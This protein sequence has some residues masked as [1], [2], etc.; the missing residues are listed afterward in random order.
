[1]KHCQHI[2]RLLATMLAVA[3][4]VFVAQ[5]EARAQADTSDTSINTEMPLTKDKL[6][7]IEDNLVKNLESQSIGMVIGG[8]QVV[9]E[10]KAKAPEHG[11]SKVIIPLMRILKDKTADRGARMMAALALFDVNSDRGNFAIQREAELSDD[12]L[13]KIVCMNLSKARKEKGAK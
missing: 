11:F 3:A 12:D 4:L 1:M 8:A 10:L 7:R 6:N 2:F 5:F 9:R 13:L